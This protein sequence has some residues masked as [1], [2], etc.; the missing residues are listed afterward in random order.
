MSG[1]DFIEG[2]MG[3]AQETLESILNFLHREYV[4]PNYLESY[5]SA[6]SGENRWQIDNR[7]DN[8]GCTPKCASHQVFGIQTMDTTRCHRCDIVDDV[9]ETTSDYI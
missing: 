2:N 3:C 6:G 4:D 9:S 7:L 8:M 5:C 1:Q